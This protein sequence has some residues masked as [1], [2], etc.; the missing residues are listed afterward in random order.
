MIKR[1]FIAPK[2][3]TPPPCEYHFIDL[4]GDEV[5]IVVYDPTISIPKSWHELPHLLDPMTK[6]DHPKLPQ[7]MSGFQLAKHLASI[8]LKFHP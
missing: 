5:A 6:S 7:G 4:E 1:Y 2:G 3:F 8:H